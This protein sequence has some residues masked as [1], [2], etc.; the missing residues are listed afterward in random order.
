MYAPQGLTEE[1]AE[2]YTLLWLKIE[3]EQPLPSLEDVQELNRLA[4]LAASRSLT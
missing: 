1:E 4:E 3:A 2:L